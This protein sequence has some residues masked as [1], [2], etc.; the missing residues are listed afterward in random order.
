MRL[1]CV[2]KCGLENYNFQDWIAHWKHGIPR[3][4]LFLGKWPKLR[5][6]YL[7]AMTTIKFKV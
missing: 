6:L 3:P 2:C 7:F 1:Q 4:D 5:A